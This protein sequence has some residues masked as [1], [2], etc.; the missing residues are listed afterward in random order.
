MDCAFR[1]NQNVFLRDLQGVFDNIITIVI[2]KITSLSHRCNLPFAT[3]R[4]HWNNNAFINLCTV[5]LI[6][7][8][9]VIN[10]NLQVVLL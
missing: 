8:L 7:Y 6:K 1:M 4:M 5:K 10:E 9:N 3:L 2:S